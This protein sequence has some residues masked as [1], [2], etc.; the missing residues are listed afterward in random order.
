MDNLAN[1]LSSASLG[2]FLLAISAMFFAAAGLL[3]GAIFTFGKVGHLEAKILALERV[4]ANQ[5][6]VIA[7]L[8]SALE[9]ALDYISKNSAADSIMA[10]NWAL[11]LEVDAANL[12]HLAD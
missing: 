1:V 2:L 10:K 11:T 4:T 3:I 7:C 12:P 9:G 8:K 5:C 6:H